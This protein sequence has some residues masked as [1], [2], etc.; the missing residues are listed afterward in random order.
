MPEVADRHLDAVRQQHLLEFSRR[1]HEHGEAHGL[2]ALPEAGD[3]LTDARV[4]AVGRIA[5]HPER[6]R[7]DEFLADVTRARVE[8][9]DGREQRST[10][11]DEL[12]AARRQCEAAA[13]ALAETIAEPRLERRELPKRLFILERG[14]PADSPD[15]R[16]HLT[17]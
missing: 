9:V 8:R 1:A 6:E 12:L 3:G 11:L 2:V 16:N 14:E 4:R 7:A 17:P 5:D 10:C 13:P 15:N